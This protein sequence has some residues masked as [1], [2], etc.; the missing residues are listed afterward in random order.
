MSTRRR[1]YRLLL[2]CYPRPFRIRHGDDLCR[3]LDAQRTEERYATRWGRAWFWVSAT[4]DAVRTG[5]RLRIEAARERRRASRPRD[6]SGGDGLIV[7]F[8]RDVR[9]GARGLRRAPLYTAVTV[10]TLGLGIGA[11]TSIFS[12]VYGVLLRPLP[13]AH[14]KELYRLWITSPEDDHSSVSPIDFEFWRAEQSAFSAIGGFTEQTGVFAADGGSR[15]AEQVFGA[16]VSVDVFR[17][18]DVTPL[19]GRWFTDEEDVRGGPDVIVLQYD[20]WR[21]RYG[22]DSSIIGHRVTVDGQPRTVVGVMPPGFYFP[23][24]SARFWSPLRGDEMLREVGITNPTRTLQFIEVVARLKPGTT[25]QAGRQALERTHARLQERH[26]INQTQGVRMEPLQQVA[27]GDARG[28]LLLF[29]GAVG[30]VLITAGANVAN[31]ALARAS[32]RGREFAMRAAL[33]ASRGRLVRQVLTESAVLGTGAGALGLV[34]AAVATRLIVTLGGTIIPRAADIRVDLFVASFCLGL[35]VASGVLFGVIPALHATRRDPAS[36]L[37]EGSRGNTATGGL[38]LR[39]LLV[40]TQVALAVVLLVGA[41]LLLDSFVRLTSVDPGFEPRQV[42]VARLALPNG[43]NA[44]DD[45]VLAFFDRVVERARALP[46]V[47]SVGTTYSPP[48]SQSNFVMTVEAEGQPTQQGADRPQAGVV[49]VDHDYFA[50]TGVQLLRGRAF[51]V[52]DRGGPRVA[53]VNETMARQF[54]SGRDPIGARFRIT[55]GISGSVESLERRYFSRDWFTVVGVVNDVHRR[56]LDEAPIAEFYQPHSQMAWASMSLVLR[57]REAPASYVGPLRQL[58]AEIDPSL[59]LTEVAPMGDL[60]S[61]SVASPRF[62]TW[63]FASFGVIAVALAMIGVYGV[64]A[65]A[66]VQRRHEIGIRV[67]LGARSTRVV[68]E[69]LGRGLGLTAIGIGI[70]LVGAV[71]ASRL[72]EALLF[73]T[74]GRNPIVYAAV[75]LAVGLVAVVACLTPARNASRVNP[76][77]V[78]RVE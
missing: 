10:L 55:G 47:V 72:M 42:L 54:W 24:R 22:A 57:T 50:A 27:E 39:Q 5:V 73:E 56:E 69:V 15:P 67:A 63:L 46:G 4:T 58:V 7:P 30:L 8:A 35:A 51:T 32:S 40:V 60:V 3:F 64:M 70:G 62:R 38:G 17:L 13:Y 37:R 61:E 26:P 59:A 41:A 1:A 68:G 31:L 48:F 11:T 76:M 78:L 9:L 36:Q 18:L 33:G 77:Q 74:S 14:P 75:A 34:L 19:M 12:V 6:L 66:V 16:R 28:T 21:N 2:G 45:R 23:D 44:G 53:I 49:L 65:F 43:S 71:T 29:L 25:P 52:A 20:L